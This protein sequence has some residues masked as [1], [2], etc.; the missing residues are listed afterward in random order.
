[1]AK[2][3]KSKTTQTLEAVAKL[4]GVSEMTVSRVLSGKGSFSLDARARVEAAVRK[5][6]Y[7][8]NR[9]AG[10][11]ASS[12]STQVAVIVPTIGNI[13]FTEVLAGIS[14]VLA[15]AGL[16]AVLG[17]TDYDLGREEALVESL[18]SWRPRA[19]I[20]AG[21]EHAPGTVKRLK[22]S[23][24]PV[25]QIMDIDGDVIDRAVGFSQAAAGAAIAEHF[26]ARGYRRIAYA[27]TDLALDTRAAKR[28][29]GFVATLDKAGVALALDQRTPLPTSLES[30]AEALIAIR[31]AHPATE[32]VYFSNDDMAVGALLHCQR[33]GISV[34]HDVAIAGF[35]GLDIGQA[36]PIRLTSIRSPRVETGEQAARSLLNP[37][38]R[39]Q[40]EKVIDLGFSFLPG[41]SS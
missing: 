6:G 34:P 12:R 18:L 26:L 13:V 32:A 35:N 3:G 37:D 31:Q 25:V 17:V 14:T 9:I 7:V 36:L 5:S 16:Q 40:T 22:R 4:A 15:P 2:T 1:M 29:A 11:L 8:P 20:I 30:G 38:G 41:E 10:S 39:R 23:G 28:F 33:A 19:V 21:L 24:V 27:G